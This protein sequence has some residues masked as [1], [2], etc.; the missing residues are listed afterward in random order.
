MTCE[1][2]TCWSEPLG[3]ACDHWK[4]EVERLRLQVARARGVVGAREYDLRA[5]EG[6]GRRCGDGDHEGRGDETLAHTRSLQATTPRPQGL[7]VEAL[8]ETVEAVAPQRRSM[9]APEH[10]NAQPSGYSLGAPPADN[11]PRGQRGLA[12]PSKA[13]LTCEPGT[14]RSRWG[15][16]EE[17][18]EPRATEDRSLD[19]LRDPPYDRC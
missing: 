13:G 3:E 8:R 19:T 4:A 15:A 2:G 6:R 14:S 9:Y 12:R 5:G 11:G 18:G 10:A 1:P 7:R 17:H 16:W